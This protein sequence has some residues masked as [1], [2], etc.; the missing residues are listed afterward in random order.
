MSNSGSNAATSGQ[1][2]DPRRQP[3]APDG[4]L[5]T[6]AAYCVCWVGVHPAPPATDSAGPRLQTALRSAGVGTPRVPGGRSGQ[7]PRLRPPG[8]GPPPGPPRHHQPN[9]SARPACAGG[10]GRRAA[11]RGRPGPA[12]LRSASGGGGPRAERAHA[13]L[14]GREAARLGGPAHGTRLSDPAQRPGPGT[15]AGLSGS[16]ARHRGRGQWLMARP[17]GQ[18]PGPVANGP[19]QWP[20]ARPSG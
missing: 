6:T 13:N 9:D 5:L 19:A 7:V 2:G 11:A 15:A 14:Y 16:A 1:T 12:G 3:E 17:S 4:L 18:L 20:I 10:G 8:T